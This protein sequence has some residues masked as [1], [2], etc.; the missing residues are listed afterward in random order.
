MIATLAAPA[1][2]LPVTLDTRA[3][4]RWNQLVKLWAEREQDGGHAYCT[5]SELNFLK[6]WNLRQPGHT[7]YRCS[8]LNE[9]LSDKAQA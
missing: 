8:T 7:K 5:E 6:G 9:N 4:R 2:T 1:T 3:Q